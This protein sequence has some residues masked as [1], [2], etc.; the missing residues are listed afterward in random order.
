MLLDSFKLQDGHDGPFCIKY[1]PRLHFLAHM[2]ATDSPLRYPGGKSQLSPFVIELLRAN[3]LIGGAYAEPFAGGCGIALK[4]LLK[5]YVSHIYINDIDRSIYALWSCVIRHSDDICELIETTPITVAEW[6]RQKL[7]QENKRARILELGFSTLFLN[8]TNRSG[9][10]SGGVIGGKEQKGKYPLD[11]RFNR[12]GLIEKIQRIADHADE[13]TLSKLDG[14]RFIRDALP[15]L[16][17]RTFVNID[18]PYFAQG[19]E[20]YTSFYEPEDHVKLARAV[21]K[22]RQPWMVTYDD[23][24]EIRAIY[25]GLPLYQQELNYSAQKKRI[26]VELLVMDPR[27]AM[28]GAAAA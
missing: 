1:A 17:K 4:L 14:E 6:S 18:P 5:G 3:D 10:I 16:P 9:I 12:T 13:I 28:P 26:G 7:I 20:L 22:I 2:P 25:R 24:A 23:V 11:C 27:L 15:T 19:P 21:R 8:R